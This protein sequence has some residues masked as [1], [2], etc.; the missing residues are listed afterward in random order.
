M[1]YL[2]ATE[3]Q[4]A[5]ALAGR[6]GVH[7][8]AGGTDWF[9]AQ[10][11][12]PFAGDLLDISRISGLRGLSRQEGQWRIGAT[13]TWTD[14]L[15]ADLPPAFA[16]LKAAAR[17]VGSVQIQNAGTVAGNICNAS[18]AA[19][20]VP[21]L[22]A[23]DA[24]VELTAQD[25]RRELPLGAF[26]T[27]PRQTLRREGELVTA[28][29][30]PDPAPGARSSFVKLGARRYLVISI[31]MVAVTAEVSGGLLRDPRIAVGA[32]SPVARR[33]PSLEARLEGMPPAEAAASLRAADVD[34]LSPID[35]VRATAGYRREAVIELLRRA[36]EEIADG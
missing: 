20:G 33:L 35:D 5:L 23:L 4:E 16:G 27:G 8:I 13:T 3:L 7:V 11:E 21:P 36:L 34:A 18:P 1:S 32:A 19:D 25:G 24:R 6:G 28:I 26:I 12:R 22:L 15:R 30:V 14:I 9:P 10:A 2:A 29:L 31:C 17:E